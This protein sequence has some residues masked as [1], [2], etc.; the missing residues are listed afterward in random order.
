MAS[1]DLYNRPHLVGIRLCCCYISFCILC[2]EFFYFIIKNGT[3]AFPNA[4]GVNYDDLV[5]SGFFYAITMIT[6]TIVDPTMK[7]SYLRL[8]CFDNIIILT[9]LAYILNIIKLE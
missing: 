1:C 3:S 6:H 4:I 2:L 7:W 9:N 5:L 8:G